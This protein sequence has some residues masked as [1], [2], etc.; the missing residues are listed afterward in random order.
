MK[1]GNRGDVVR[2]LLVA[3]SYLLLS[4]RLAAQATGT[5]TGDVRGRVEDV[6]GGVVAEVL[7]IATNSESGLSRSDVT[8]K[9]GE[10]VIRLLPPGRYRLIASRTGFRT[11]EVE[12]VRVTLGS[13]TPIV[14]RL[15]IGAVDES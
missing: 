4:A 9:D 10:F 7:V 14:L 11:A 5:T 13:S 3:G 6:S 12:E 15:E 2:Q 8:R 1:A